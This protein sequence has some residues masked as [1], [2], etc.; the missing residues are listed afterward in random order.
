MSRGRKPLSYL[1]SNNW[2]DIF[3]NSLPTYIGILNTYFTT[4]NY[5]FVAIGDCLKKLSF[6]IPKG[7]N[8]KEIHSSGKHPVISQSKEYVI[9]YSD[10]TDLLVD[11]DFPLIVFG[12]HSKTI[13]YVDEPFI[14]GAD[15]VK[16]VKPISSFNERF[17]Y[18]FI[19]GI[20]TD[21]K[22]YGRH[23]SLLRNGLIAKIED[24]ELQVKVVEFLD[25]LKADTYSNKNAFFNASLENKIYEL[26]KIQLKGNAISTELTHQLT[27]VKKLRQQLLQDAVQGKLVAP[28]PLERAEGEAF[29]P[30]SELLKKIK[31]ERQ[32]LIAEKKLKKEKELPPIKPEEIPFVIPENWVWCRFG[33]I[34]ISIIGGGTPSTSNLDF[35]NGNMPWASV[36]DLNTKYLL[37]T[38]D[39]ITELAIKSSSTNL[40]PKGNIIVCTRMGLGKIVINK[41]DTAI[42]QD[43]K[44]LFL[45]KF[46][47]QE[48]FYNHYKT[49]EII[50]KGMTVNGIRQEELLNYLIPIPPL[51]E[52]NRIVQKLD[53]LMQNCNELETSI[54]QSESQNE[55]LLQQVLREALRKEPVEV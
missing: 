12:D 17:F 16:L 7:L 35:W 1:P 51:V 37:D 15:G 48:Y 11:K 31:D 22:D 42:N 18:Y 21:T 24:L 3:W 27:L 6:T 49:L 40:I 50:G 36:K 33:E 54:K 26:Q 13:K 38:K 45:S 20:I 9:G 55:K 44:A 53:E 2:E 5:E 30:A 32:K 23:F 8:S 25:S 41:I 28:S 43:L 34:I 4:N 14:I 39:K 46:I 10:R 47:N 19:F 29:E 52:Q